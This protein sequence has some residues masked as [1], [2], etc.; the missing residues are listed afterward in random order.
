MRESD[1]YIAV[2]T[3]MLQQFDL[4]QSPLR[5]DLFTEDVG[6]FFDGYSFPRV[7]IRSSAVNQLAA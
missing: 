5:K 7:I 3:K 6:N 4:S 2:T 1:T